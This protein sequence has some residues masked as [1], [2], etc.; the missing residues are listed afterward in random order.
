MSAR[1]QTAGNQHASLY[2]ATITT[3]LSAV[4]QTPVVVGPAKILGLQATFTYG[5]AGTTAK[6][7][8]QTSLDGGATW[9][10]IACFSF[11]T[12]TAKKLSTVV[13]DPATPLTPATVPGSGALTADTVLNGIIGD[14]IRALVT[15]TGTYAGGTTLAV[16]VAVVTKG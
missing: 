8:V 15:T 5:S 16:A 11:T 4:E 9:F 7:W 10:D 6:V 1:E 14:R 3:A 13:A 12:S 2:S